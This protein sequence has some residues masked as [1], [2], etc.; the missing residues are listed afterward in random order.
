MTNV[1][2]SIAIRVL[3][4]GSRV[5]MSPFKRACHNYLGVITAVA[6][7]KPVLALTFDDGP[8]HEYTPAL[9]EILAKYRARG[10]FFMIGELAA[11]HPDVVRAAAQAGHAV[12]NHSWSHLSFPL[13]TARERYDQLRRCEEALAPYGEKLFRPPYCHQTARSR[14]HT[15]R[16]GYDVVGFNAHAEDWLSR[17]PAWMYE[18]LVCQAR[19]GAIVILHDNIYRSVLP[20]AQHDRKPMLAALDHALEQL[21]ER[22]SF[23]TVPELLRMGRPVREHWYRSGLADM[24]P[25]LERH[26]MAQRRPEEERIML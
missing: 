10:T 7:D 18:R 5:L 3:R 20:A 4:R 9:L 16:S 6:T 13:M 19:P 15:L 21:Q 17:P 14:W 12:A 24:Q 22:F 2:K 1:D 11:Q 23:V 8:H 25:A 26:L